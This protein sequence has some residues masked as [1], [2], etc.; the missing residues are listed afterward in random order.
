M[1]VP[2]EPHPT[3]FHLINSELWFLSLAI[4]LYLSL[5]MTY[6]PQGTSIN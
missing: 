2:L 1:M 5:V 6:E 4:V 3:I